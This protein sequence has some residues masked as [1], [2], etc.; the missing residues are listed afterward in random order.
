MRDVNVKMQKY[1]Q[2]EFI[3]RSYLSEVFD[4]GVGGSSVRPSVSYVQR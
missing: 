4:N 3:V 1:V 2:A